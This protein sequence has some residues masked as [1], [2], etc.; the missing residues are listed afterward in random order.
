MDTSD[1]DLCLNRKQDEILEE[2]RQPHFTKKYIYALFD[3][4][5]PLKDKDS[6]QKDLLALRF[7]HTLRREY[8]DVR[9]EYKGKSD[10]EQAAV[11]FRYGY[12]YRE[13][14]LIDI[15]ADT[16]GWNWT[17]QQRE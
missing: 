9:T 13:I 1:I 16:E 15:I 5:H 7:A 17:D 14:M 8:K 6:V 2:L 12:W 11:L 4:E 3:L 10:S